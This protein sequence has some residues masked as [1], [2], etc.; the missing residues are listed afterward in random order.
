MNSI[1]NTPK[2]AR[3]EARASD[4]LHAVPE[5]GWTVSKCKNQPTE[6][7]A[8]VLSELGANDVLHDVA[9][10]LSQDCMLLLLC[11]SAAL[12]LCSTMERASNKSLTLAW[13]ACAVYVMFFCKL[14]YLFFVSSSASS[15]GSG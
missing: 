5:P 9:K 6:R 11:A 7:R 8:W 10:Y 15:L 2:R 14:T 4:E 1:S 13:H 12:T 3:A